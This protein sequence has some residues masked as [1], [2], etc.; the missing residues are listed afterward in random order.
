MIATVTE[1]DFAALTDPL[2]GELTAHCYRMLGSTHDAEDQV[3]ETYLRAWRAYHSFEGRSSLRTWM[4]QIATR[5]CLTALQQR[6]R[7][8]LPTGLGAPS[9]DPAAELETRPEVPWLEPVP[10]TLIAGPGADP[11]TVATTRDSV[12]LAFVAALQ[13]LTALQRAVLILRD[14]LAFSAAE[15]AETLDITVASANSALQR[16]RAGVERLTSAGGGLS[17]SAGG[18]PAIDGNRLAAR[19]LGPRERDLLDRYLAAFENYDTDAVVAL[20]AEDATWEMPPY[21]GW[22]EGADAI[23]VLIRTQC[24]AK[25]PGDLRFVAT[26]ANGQPAFA[27]W[28]REPDGVHRAFQIHVLDLAT[29]PDGRPVVKHVACFFDTSLFRAFGLP[30]VLPPAS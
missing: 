7:R 24:P 20:L 23:G 11:A 3:Q 30:E 17:D 14:V 28:L 10:D 1:Q 12:R 21:T 9:S 4:Y 25:G 26:S 18:D 29:L 6:A 5:T 27:A 19:A 22:Y 2:R 8:P 13:N 16:A 15:T